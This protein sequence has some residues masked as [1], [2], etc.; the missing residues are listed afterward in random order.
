MASALTELNHSLEVMREL[1]LVFIVVL[2]LIVV[3]VLVRRLVGARRASQWGEGKG[4]T[5]GCGYLRPIEGIQYTGKSYSKTLTDLCRAFMPS[6]TRFKPLTSE[7]IFPN[8]RNHISSE[9]D[10]WD[11]RVISPGVGKLNEGLDKFQFIQNGNLQR[12]IVYGLGYT[13]LLILSV[14]VFG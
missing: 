4:S 13:L 1:G 7:E 12:Y 5:W 9:S 10:F 3:M 11:S 2:S 6:T 8:G 14:V